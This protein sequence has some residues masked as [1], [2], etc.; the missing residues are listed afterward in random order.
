MNVSVVSTQQPLS[1]MRSW[2]PGRC[3]MRSAKKVP[4]VVPPPSF[5]CAPTVV[6]TSLGA[7]IFMPR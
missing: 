2:R 3:S 5:L 1:W 7:A 6:R 4:R